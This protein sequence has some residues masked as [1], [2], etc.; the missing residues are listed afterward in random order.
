MPGPLGFPSLVGQLVIGYA[1]LCAFTLVQL[2]VALHDHRRAVSIHVGFLALSF[3]WGLTRVLVWARPTPLEGACAHAA[4]A[5]LGTVLHCAIYALLL[6]FLANLL[7]PLERAH[8][9]LA[10]GRT[11]LPTPAVSSPPTY[12]SASFIQGSVPESD[13]AESPF[14]GSILG[15]RGGLRRERA[16]H[17]HDRA[18][19]PA[20]KRRGNAIVY[21]LFNIGVVA[22]AGFL[23]GG[24]CTG[25]PADRRMLHAVLCTTLHVVFLFLLVYFCSRLLRFSETERVQLLAYIA[26][27]GCAAHTLW[28][29]SGLWVAPAYAESILNPD[30]P[31]ALSPFQLVATVV[32]ETPMWAVLLFMWA[33]GP[34]PAPK[35][36]GAVA[37]NGHS[38]DLMFYPSNSYG[39]AV[40]KGPG[41]SSE[42]K[43]SVVLAA[44]NGHGGASTHQPLP[45]HEHHWNGSLSTYDSVDAETYL[46]TSLS[47]VRCAALGPPL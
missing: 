10:P 6:L 11:P 36:S 47:G 39:T 14:M 37:I 45:G 1:A 8:R 23:F 22:A 5:G 9:L 43:P 27:G 7:L 4:L 35:S 32:A 19:T 12:G 21:A 33:D 13:I 31:V 41:P 46:P 26:I 17:H 38:Q 44:G 2:I 25:R 34:R 16:A 18:G 42:V 40:S 24:A 15:G 28:H 30:P 20:A 3:A 29:I